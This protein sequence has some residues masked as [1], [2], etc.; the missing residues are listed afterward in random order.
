ME[1][2]IYIP[3]AKLEAFVKLVKKCNKYFKLDYKLG[4]CTQKRFSHL[5]ADNNLYWQFHSVYPCEL[6]QIRTNDWVLVATILDGT[7][8]VADTSK[9]VT[10]ADNHGKDVYIC[11][12]CGHRMKNS[13]I[14]RNIKTNEEKQVGGECVKKFGIECKPQTFSAIISELNVYFSGSVSD[15]WNYSFTDNSALESH[16]VDDIMACAKAYYNTNKVWRKGYYDNNGFYVKSPSLEEL[17][18]VVLS[19]SRELIPKDYINKVKEFIKA[20]LAK[21][22]ELS[23]FEENMLRI[24]NDYYCTINDSVFCYFMVKKYE[25]YL[26]EQ[27]NDFKYKKGDYVSFIAK[28]VSKKTINGYFG[29]YEKVIMETEKGFILE[30]NGKVNANLNESIK[31]FAVI[32]CIGK[33]NEIILDRVTKAPKKGETIINLN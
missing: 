29:S 7:M 17:N 33:N 21:K 28:V 22:N 11:E 23:E 6:S 26:F 4:E 31:G 10:F 5:D 27:M 1:N 14:I 9:E 25:S 19:S 2:L 32:K 18:N 16:Y 15:R 20:D 30:R 3:S 12:E 8:V 24:A 13:Y